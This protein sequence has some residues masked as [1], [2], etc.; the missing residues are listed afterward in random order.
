MGLQGSHW[1]GKSQGN[2]KKVPGQG[3]VREFEKS[4][5]I[6]RKTEKVRVFFAFLR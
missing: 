6:F 1:S 2:L 5:R 3:K 4:Q